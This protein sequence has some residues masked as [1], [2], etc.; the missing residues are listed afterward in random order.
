MGQRRN[1]PKEFKPEAINLVVT[2][3]VSVALAGKIWTSQRTS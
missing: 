1:Y 3:G 2:T